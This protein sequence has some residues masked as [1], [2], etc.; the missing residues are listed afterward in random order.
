MLFDYMDPHTLK[1]SRTLAEYERN[2]IEPF[3]NPFRLVG[4]TWTHRVLTFE[5]WGLCFGCF[6]LGLGLF[7]GLG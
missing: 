7:E 3:R 1:P 2:L 4:T 6:G 5:V